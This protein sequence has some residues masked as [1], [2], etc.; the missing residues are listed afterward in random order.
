MGSGVVGGGSGRR[1][2]NVS[3][4]ESLDKALDDLEDLDFADSIV[5][6]KPKVVEKPGLQ[7]IAR[8]VVVH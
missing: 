6:A 5:K 1:R 2:W 7:A 4:N 3:M 8:L